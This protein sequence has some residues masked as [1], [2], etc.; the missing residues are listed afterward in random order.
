MDLYLIR[1][2]EA[3]PVG[4]SGIE[5]DADRPLTE[6][7]H[8]QCAVLA[9]ALLRHKVRLERVLT[10]PLLRA[11]ET[12]EGLLT[13]WTAPLPEMQVCDQLAPGGRRR[14]LT[15]ML[16]NLGLDAVAVVGHMPDLALYAAWLIGS[17]RAQIDLAKAGVACVHFEDQP[18]KAAGSLAWLVTPDWYAPST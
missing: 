9:V 15:K 3:E 10:S 7:G 17:K 6:A 13:H 11:R 1:H 12:A 14:K 8:G 5:A 4:I 16:S 2:A 18:A